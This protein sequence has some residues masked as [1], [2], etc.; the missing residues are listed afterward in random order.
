MGAMRVLITSRGSSSHLLPLV[1]F[2]RACADAGHE[3]LGAVQGQHRANIERIGL[4]FTVGRRSRVPAMR[5]T[6]SQIK[7]SLGHVRSARAL[8]RRLDRDPFGGL[9]P[10]LWLRACGASSWLWMCCWP[11]LGAS[12]TDRRPRHADT[13][14]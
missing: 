12:L 7:H 14:R 5:T 9:D 13:D 10:E 8:D 2:A 1:P 11:M 3:V 4:P 6:L